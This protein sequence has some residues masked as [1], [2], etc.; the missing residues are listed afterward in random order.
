MVI[1]ESY[2]NLLRVCDFD[3]QILVQSKNEDILNNI[4]KI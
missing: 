2:K 3:I 4:E 1:L